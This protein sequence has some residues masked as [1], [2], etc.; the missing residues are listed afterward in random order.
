MHM[1]LNMFYIVSVKY[2]SVLSNIWNRDK[3]SWLL[4]LLLS[5]F[6]HPS[7]PSHI[8]TPSALGLMKAFCSCAHVHECKQSITL[9]SKHLNLE[10][11][12]HFYR[13]FVIHVSGKW[14]I[15]FHADFF[16]VLMGYQCVSPHLSQNIQS[17]HS[18]NKTAVLL[19]ISLIL[20]SVF[21][22]SSSTL[23]STLI[24]YVCNVYQSIH[25]S[26][27]QLV[28]DSVNWCAHH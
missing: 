16:S 25:Q 17:H 12:S 15:T 21:H 19:S 13:Y 14:L 26:I 3:I 18:H 4:F 28:M 7:L 5:S 11:R 8:R 1:D 9:I 23:P 2:T 27:N 10:L 6:I 22:P 24:Q 20:H